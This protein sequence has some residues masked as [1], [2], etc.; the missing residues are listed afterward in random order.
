MVFPCS[1][2]FIQNWINVIE[3]E[4]LKELVLAMK[5]RLNLWSAKDKEKSER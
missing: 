1:Y 3:M 5:I 4:Q 2:P